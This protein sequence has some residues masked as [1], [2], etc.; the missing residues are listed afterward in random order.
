LAKTEKSQVEKP[1]SD[2][3]AKPQ[4]STG[5]NLIDDL[6]YGIAEKTVQ[7][8]SYWPDSMRRPY[9]PDDLY[10]KTN[11]YSIYEDMTKDDQ[12]TV[13]MEIKKDLVLGS[14][15]DIVC[16]DQGDQLI[17]EDL[18]K[19]LIEDP[20][21]P[22]DDQLKDV[23]TAYE[24]GFSLSE[25][26]FQFRPDGS[27]SLKQIKTRHP[28]TWLI[29]T[30]KHGNVEKYEQL[31]QRENIDCDPNSLI[32]FV[33]NRRFQ[34][35]Y[36]LSDLRAA[37]NAW[38]TKRQ[39]TRYFGIFLEKAASPIPIAKYP[40][41]TPQSEVTNI[42]NAIKKFQTKTAMAI[43]K[44][45]EIQF[46]EA[47]NTGEAF[48]RGINIFNMFIGRSMLIPD[49]LGFQ[50]SETSGGSYALG[51]D[52]IRILFKH[53]ERR[54]ASLERVVNKEILEPIVFYNH[55]FVD[56][57]PK[58]KLRPISD[59]HLVELAKLWIEVVKGRIY[60]PTEEEINHFR[61][62]AQFPEGDVIIPS[63]QSAEGTQNE[64]DEKQKKTKENK[65]QKKDKEDYTDQTNS[66]LESQGVDQKQYKT[67]LPPGPYYKKCNF[68]AIES[69]MD[70][71]KDRVLNEA[72]PLI[73]QIYNDLFD[74]IE[75]K[76]IIKD[77]RSDR[78]EDLKLKNLKDLKLILKKNFREL[79]VDAKMEAQGEL[80][81]GAQYRTPLPDDKFLDFLEDETFQFVGDW[82]YNVTKNAGVTL[83]E[84]I[85]DGKPLSAV[86]DFLDDQGIQESMVSLERFSRTKITDVMNRGRLAFF[87]DSGVV[88][89]YQYSAILDDRTT[90][91][92]SGL[93]GKIFKAGSEPVPPMHFNCRSLL[94]PITKF[95]DYE[96]DSKV[97]SKPIDQFIEDNKGDG[98]SKR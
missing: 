30:D 79:Y 1:S 28:S 88:A 78:I 83:R 6:Y 75:R 41:N 20:K 84:A 17:R 63:A 76:K 54:R 97:G 15:W 29:H 25:K 69:Q 66:S 56:H 89:A 81:K 73:K 85:R 24:F 26:I 19:A 9:N 47:K 3:K 37:Y 64:E 49:L 72:R 4:A 31:G 86:I 46:L 51:K 22:F 10:Q 67:A 33:N 48:E 98:F 80:L 70:R 90:E 94:I 18:E 34:N 5:V 38:F 61:K 16:E 82:S 57:F 96:T 68:K 12:V 43:P 74:Q 2:P 8:S 91:I 40:L 53:I 58:F 7:E 60:Q 44:E 65:S 95:E 50:G 59:E 77:Q 11:D 21:V 42:Y 62:L 93:D 55:G 27:L 32:H 14:G 87:N 23:L 52:Q 36:G 35:P 45:F 13:C 92:C 39:I 71:F